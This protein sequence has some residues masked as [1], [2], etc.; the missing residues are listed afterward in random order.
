MAIV[1]GGQSRWHGTES[2]GRLAAAALY[3]CSIL[4]RGM[5][6]K[7]GGLRP[8]WPGKWPRNPRGA[9][10]SHSATTFTTRQGGNLGDRATVPAKPQANCG[11]SG[12]NVLE[13]FS[14]GIIEN[15][16]IGREPTAGGPPGPRRDGP[17]YE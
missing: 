13:G 8:R 12:M 4:G 15:P 17:P 9:K 6:E 10:R 11:A 2:A 7:K 16:A 3:R 14:G 5:R 1:S